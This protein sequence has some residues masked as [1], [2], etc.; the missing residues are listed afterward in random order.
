M[1]GVG[2]AADNFQNSTKKMFKAIAAM[3]ENRVIGANGQIPWHLPE[4]FKW[5]R[6]STWGKT[7]LMGRRTFESLGKPLV[8][9]LNIVLTRNPKL[10]AGDPE[11]PQV[12]RDAKF[13]KAAEKILRR[14]PAE[15]PSL[16]GIDGGKPGVENTHVILWGDL[17]R[18]VKDDRGAEI[19]VIGGASI[20]Q[21]TLDFC[22]DL[23]LTRVRRTVDGDTF[24]PPFE[25][26]FVHVG[27]VMETA[28]FTVEHHQ[29]RQRQIA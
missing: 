10:L 17:D 24:F 26:Q 27:N 29:H 3:S 28:D 20:Y 21:Q 13:G 4:D 12:F 16:P 5:F 19:W 6:R 9:R 22:S 1:I 2:N 7:V 18:L 8:N 14:N 15:Q 23:Y 11:R 25:D